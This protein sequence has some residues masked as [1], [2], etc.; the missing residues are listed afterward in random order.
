MGKYSFW[1]RGAAVN[2]SSHTLSYSVSSWCQKCFIVSKQKEN[3]LKRGHAG[4]SLISFFFWSSQI[5]RYPQS[6]THWQMRAEQTFLSCASDNLLLNIIQLLCLFLQ[7]KPSP[8]A[9]QIFTLAPSAP[10][11]S[12]QQL[13]NTAGIRAEGKSD[14]RHFVFPYVRMMD[15]PFVQQILT[16]RL[17]SNFASTPF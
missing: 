16:H 10:T 12:H 4:S 11:K 13:P 15:P 14:L 2:Q 7:S 6:R 3:I 17:W 5:E 9:G 1:C 8:C